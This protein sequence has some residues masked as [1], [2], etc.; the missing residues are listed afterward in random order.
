[1]AAIAGVA[2]LGLGALVLERWRAA[3]PPPA[4]LDASPALAVPV[5]SIQPLAGFQ[6]RRRFTGRVEAARE[7]L[8]GFELDGLLVEV[9]VAEGEAV[10]RGQLLAR[11]DTAR[12][13]ARRGELRAALADARAD[14]ALAK[15]TVERFQGVFKSGGVTQQALDGAREGFRGAE[16]GVALAEARI[17]SLEVDIV[18]TALKAPFD[19][20]VTDRLADEGRVLSAGSPVLKVQETARPEIRVGVAGH[21][22][23]ALTPGNTY[24]MAWNGRAF[25]ARLRSI[26]P[27]RAPGQ[28]T[29]DALFEPLDL[30][31]G[32]RPGDLVDLT[33]E[34]R[35]PERGFWVPLSAL[36]EGARGLW[37]VYAAQALT[38]GAAGAL[39]ASHQ[40]AP[41][42]VEVLHQDGE[43]AYVRGPVH[44]RELIVRDG[45]HRV[46]PGQWVRVSDAGAEPIVMGGR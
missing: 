32:P 11:L 15:L 46:V 14:L 12:L 19:G 42:I 36:A 3:V 24:R 28:R 25:R 38:D 44:A 2:A 35:M 13:R 8:L 40:L 33:L 34:S 23:A 7:S 17:A 41:R 30:P 18:K 20:V 21:P 45:L 29:V 10:A 27:V 39:D 9:L 5:V 6:L 22:V 31:A 4:T 1:L 43:R 26:L 16:A 37:T